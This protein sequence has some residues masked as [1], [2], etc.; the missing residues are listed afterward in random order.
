[1]WFASWFQFLQW[2]A[3]K[4][5]SAGGQRG[6]PRRT[7]RALFVEALEGRTV[8]SGLGGAAGLGGLA[9]PIAAALTAPASGAGSDALPSPDHTTPTMSA[10]AQ[11][12]AAG[13]GDEASPGTDAP[14]AGATSAAEEAP[15][16]P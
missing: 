6:R 7:A 13:L 15:A 11:D 3:V 10:P 9:A 4:G 16:C 8:P 5:S 14:A 12:P 1:M 2:A